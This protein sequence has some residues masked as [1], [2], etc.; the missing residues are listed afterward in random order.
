[1]TPYLYAAILALGIAIGG[2]A[3]YYFEHNQVL[4]MELA[5]S[6]QKIEAAEILA[7]E[8]KKVTA[9]EN[10]QRNANLELDKSHDAFIK[11]SNA[12]DI[13]LNDTINQLQ[14]TKRGQSSGSTT[15]GSNNST[16]HSTDDTE[17]TWVSRKLLTY[18]AGESKRAQQDGIDKNTLLEF[19]IKDNCGI[20]KQK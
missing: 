12:Y 20:L 15:T 4:S 8:T 1:M 18:L 5:I 11:T 7:E 9:A 19:V 17:F 10:A 6:H 14:F 2:G 3:A 13:K 16:E